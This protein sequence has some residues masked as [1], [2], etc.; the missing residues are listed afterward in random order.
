MTATTEG[1]L[2]EVSA[3]GKAITLSDEEVAKIKEVMGEKDGAKHVADIEAAHETDLMRANGKMEAKAAACK[4]RADS[5]DPCSA[6][7]LAELDKWE[8]AKAEGTD[9]L[10]L[11]HKAQDERKQAA[12]TAT[13][14][15]S[16]LEVSG[17]GKAITVSEK[18]IA[19]I[20]E[21]MRANGEMEGMAADCKE[22]ADS[23]VP[24]P[25]GALAEVEKW[26]KAKAKG[27]DALSLLHKAQDERKQAALTAT[28]EGSLLEVSGPGKAITVSE[29]EIAEINE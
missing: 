9:D 2:L 12:L 18:E 6:E 13:T 14:E 5:S 16:L 25:A 21:A 26:E 17:P 3:P 29:K 24:C 1:S 20:N 28:T 8:K 27:T 23:S 7:E 4:D 11:L 19:E 10:S 15:G 22:R